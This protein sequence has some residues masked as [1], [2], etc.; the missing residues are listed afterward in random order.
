MEGSI[1]SIQDWCASRRLQL[2]PGKTE[3]IWFC[4][5]TKLN[6]LSD[7]DLSLHLSSVVAPLQRVINAAAARLIAKLGTHDH[8]TNTE[9]AA[10]AACCMVRCIQRLPV[11][12]PRQNRSQ[13]TADYGP[14]DAR[15]RDCCS[16]TYSLRRCRSLL[17]AKDPR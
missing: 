2:N 1:V 13:H 9:T 8:V 4:S 12:V 3:L 17:G 7:G 10:L 16:K 15:L 5:K 11:D 6:L 14:S